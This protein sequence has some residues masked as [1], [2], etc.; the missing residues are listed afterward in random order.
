MEHGL[1]PTGQPWRK[2]DWTQQMSNRFPRDPDTA[3]YGDLPRAYMTTDAEY[4]HD[5]A[6]KAAS[7]QLRMALGLGDDFD[8]NMQYI[9]DAINRPA[10]IRISDQFPA[11]K[12]TRGLHSNEIIP[13]EYLEVVYAPDIPIDEPLNYDQW[14]ELT[15][16]HFAEAGLPQYHVPRNFLSLHVED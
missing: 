12:N 1:K 5:F 3:Y 14:E 9:T 16:R 10:I 8:P 2:D 6:R 15:D 4:A 11:R 13:P 7:R